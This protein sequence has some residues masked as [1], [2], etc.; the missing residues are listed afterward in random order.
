MVL[1]L[2]DRFWPKVWKGEEDDCWPWIGASNPKGYGH[3]RYYCVYYQA[4][5][6]SWQIHFG[7]IPEDKWVLHKCDNS[8]C[9][10]PNH[11]FLGD[12]RTMIFKI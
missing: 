2:E 4:H 8:S 7:P 12:V 5:R 3:L 11:L 1:P 6:I 10:N 9:V